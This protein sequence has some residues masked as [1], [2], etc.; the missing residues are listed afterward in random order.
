MTTIGNEVDLSDTRISTAQNPDKGL[1]L[2]VDRRQKY[3]LVQ[4]EG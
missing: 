1:A 4:V 3:T 2:F